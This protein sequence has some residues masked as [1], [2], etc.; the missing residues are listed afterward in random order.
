VD[1][2][3]TGTFQ[4]YLPGTGEGTL[5]RS[6]HSVAG[7][8]ALI[9]AFNTSIPTLGDNCGADSPTGRC[10]SNFPGFGDPIVRLALL[11]PGTQIG[12][13][14]VISQDILLT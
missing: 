10:D 12:S 14:S 13:D 4:S 11:P 3:R 5:G 7:V 2:S 1:L 9:A 8:N 6:A